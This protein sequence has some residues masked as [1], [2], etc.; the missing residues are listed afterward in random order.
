MCIAGQ[1]MTGARVARIVAVSRSPERPV[2]MS[3]ITRAVAGQTSTRSADCPI[4]VWGIG[5]SGSWNS[6]VRAGSLARAEKVVAPTISS[7]PSVST[8]V[9]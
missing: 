9:T 5:V 2:R 1:I 8:G 6:E 4:R 3:E 7:A